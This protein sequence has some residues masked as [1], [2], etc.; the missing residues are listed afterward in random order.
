[1]IA[2]ALSGCLNNYLARFFGFAQT[3]RTGKEVPKNRQII[4]ET[5][6]WLAK[7]LTLKLQ[8]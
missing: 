7:N 8:F 4:D 1:V 3:P 5:P 6:T 2:F